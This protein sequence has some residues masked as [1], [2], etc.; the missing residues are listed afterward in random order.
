[1]FSLD[2]HSRINLL[3]ELWW[4]ENGSRACWPPSS[5]HQLTV[6]LYFM[7]FSKREKKSVWGFSICLIEYEGGRANC[8]G[9]MWWPVFV[10]CHHSSHTL[11]DIVW[12]RC[13]PAGETRA[14]SLKKPLYVRFFFFFGLPVLLKVFFKVSLQLYVHRNT[15]SAPCRYSHVANIEIEWH[16]TPLCLQQ[17]MPLWEE[18]VFLSLKNRY[19]LNTLCSVARI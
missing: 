4:G 17:I 8:G 12:L 13:P 3:Q 11:F 5:S 10:P 14:I 18:S 2:S 9:G 7:N 19:L 6:L 15:H 16:F 1:M